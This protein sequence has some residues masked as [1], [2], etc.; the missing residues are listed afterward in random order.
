[1]QTSKVAVELPAKDS[2][3]QDLAHVNEKQA[4][5]QGD[6]LSEPQTPTTSQAPSESDST[7]PTTPSS[8]TL[9]SRSRDQIQTP[10]QTTIVPVVPILPQVPVT[11]KQ[12]GSAHEH[13]QRDSAQVP[14]EAAG[15]ESPEQATTPAPAAPKSWADLVR[16]KSARAAGIVPNVPVESDNLQAPRSESLGDVLA[17]L[18]PNVDQFGEKIAFLEPRGLVNTGNMCYMNSVCLLFSNFFQ[19]CVL[20]VFQVL[21]I[22]AFCVPFY[23]FLDYI[24]H[25]ATHSFKSD[26]P[27]IDAT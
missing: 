16:A 9:A 13:E 27:L 15:Q 7:H 11:P 12:S 14:G 1:M 10:K 21:Q 19:F 8:T 23:Q 5:T 24:G 25:R 3:K 20:I 18:G 26:V 6:S 17:S 22:L 2:Q 4:S